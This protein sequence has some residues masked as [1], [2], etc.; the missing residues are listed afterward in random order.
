MPNNIPS[1]IFW[2]KEI[3]GLVRISDGGDYTLP[4]REWKYKIILQRVLYIVMEGITVVTVTNH[5]PYYG[6]WKDWGLGSICSHGSRLVEGVGVQEMRMELT[7]GEKQE[8]ELEGFARASCKGHSVSV[9]AAWITW[10]S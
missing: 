3:T 2:S 9:L 5:L 6:S 4:L 10:A 7:S 8:Q 1:T